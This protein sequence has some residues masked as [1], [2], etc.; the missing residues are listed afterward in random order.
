MIVGIGVDVFAVA[1]IARELAKD[2]HGLREQLFTPA[3]IAYCE[4]K[5]YPAPHYAVRFAAKEALFKA[6]GSEQ[7]NGSS[8][9]EVEVRNESSGQSRLVLHG[10]LRDAASALHADRI[11]V[12][13]SHTRK[14][15][16]ANVVLESTE[17]R[18]EER[19]D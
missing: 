10:R 1:R 17:E 16:V 4:A 9:R 8:W 5:R 15:V 2:S 7:V 11:F 13:L 3:E 12:S 19:R 18:P 14:W 6:L